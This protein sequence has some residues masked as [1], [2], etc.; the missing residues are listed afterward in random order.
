MLINQSS[1]KG[2]RGLL[3]TVGF[4]LP[5]NRKVGRPCGQFQ[6]LSKEDKLV[7]TFCIYLRSKVSPIIILFRQALDANIW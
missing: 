1:N 3:V 2:L 6:G 4:I 5:K 7:T